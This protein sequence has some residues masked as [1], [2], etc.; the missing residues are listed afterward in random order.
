VEDVQ[1][2][3]KEGDGIT[4]T[5]SEG[6]GRAVKPIF[7]SSYENIEKICR[8][9]TAEKIGSCIAELG[10]NMV[11][12]TVGSDVQWYHVFD[13]EGG[14]GEGLNVWPRE[15]E[16]RGRDINEIMSGEAIP[17][18]DQYGSTYPYWLDFLYTLKI[19]DL[20]FLMCPNIY[21]AVMAYD[22]TPESLEN[23]WREF[24]RMVG[25]V[26]R[27]GHMVPIVQLGTESQLYRD[28][29]KNGVEDYCDICKVLIPGIKRRLPGAVISGDGSNTRNPKWDEAVASIPGVDA[30]RLYLQV[31]SWRGGDDYPGMRR[32]VN[33]DLPE[34]VNDFMEMCP[35][36][37]IVFLQM[38]VKNPYSSTVAHG[39]Y[40][41][42]VYLKMAKLNL[43]KDDIILSA[44]Q[45]NLKNLFS[46]DLLPMPPYFGMLAVKDIWGGV[47]RTSSVEGTDD[48]VTFAVKK[49]DGYHAVII[50]PTEEPVKIDKVVVD[51]ETREDYEVSGY[52]GAL[53]SR[54]VSEFDSL[55][56]PAYSWAKVF[57]PPSSSRLRQT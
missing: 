31:D 47:A 5:I 32:R 39:L 51:G 46:R 11:G 20:D 42:E 36:K 17:R 9:E 33:V 40:L 22:G 21:T 26:T 38:A 23:F 48:L 25:D 7:S 43:E 14:D 12:Y 18:K 13:E 50:N 45:F 4:L 8:V 37:R 29:F 15:V 16:A 54:T 27:A 49:Q 55:E 10:L 41:A 2:E 3:T 19:A 35:G 53:D 24:D 44:N 34:M 52:Y 1:E 57:V 28:L 6:A 30:L 56:M